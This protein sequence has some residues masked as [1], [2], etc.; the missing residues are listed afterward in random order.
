MGIPFRKNFK[1]SHLK[2]L[3]T[4]K[5][6]E[7]ISCALLHFHAVAVTSNNGRRQNPEPRLQ[8]EPRPTS[9]CSEWQQFRCH[10]WWWFWWLYLLWS[11][12]QTS[13]CRAS[14]SLGLIPLAGANLCAG[15]R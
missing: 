14:E 1:S 13:W 3:K 7:Q 4:S 15:G 5:K 11:R 10:Q 12:L 8:D 6:D 2:F 9:L